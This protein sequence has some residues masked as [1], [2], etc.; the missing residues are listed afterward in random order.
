[1]YFV[2]GDFVLFVNVTF[3]MPE[4]AHRLLAVDLNYKMDNFFKSLNP[5]HR[6][7]LLALPLCLILIKFFLYLKH[8]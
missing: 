7:V 2:L 4:T 8:R 5:E 1:V 6:I 3:T